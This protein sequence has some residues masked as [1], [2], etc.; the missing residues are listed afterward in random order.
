LSVLL[1]KLLQWTKPAAHYYYASTLSSLAAIQQRPINIAIHERKPPED[2]K[3]SIHSL[4]N[5]SFKGFELTVRVDN[6][7]RLQMERSFID[8]SILPIHVLNPLIEDME[9]LIYQ[10]AAISKAEQ[11]RVHLKTIVND[12]CRKFHI[13]GYDLR[14]LCSYAGPGT[15]WT[16][17]ENVNRKYLGEGTNEQIIKDWGYINQLKSYDVVILKGEL[18]H[19]RTGNGIVHRSPEIEQSKEKRLVLRIDC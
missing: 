9:L 11:V 12:A 17:N 3:E 2:L 7:V 5:S 18:P 19:K 15:E 13:D 4:V 1:S 8:K 14:M 10:F 6:E 16:Y